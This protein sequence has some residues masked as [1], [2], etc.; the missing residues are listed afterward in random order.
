[1]EKVF[2]GGD[3]EYGVILKDNPT[4]IIPP[5]IFE[6]CF[7]MARIGTENEEMPDKHPIYAA[8]KDGITIM[9]DGAAFEATIPP[10]S[11][12]EEFKYYHEKARDLL[13]D[14]V[15]PFGGEI[16]PYP[17]YHFHLNNMKN[18]GIEDPENDEGLWM[19][20]QFGCDAQFNIH[21]RFQH[22]AGKLKDV[23]KFTLRTFGGHIHFSME[24]IDL[25]RLVNE[26]IS[27]FDILVTPVVLGYS[28]FPEQEKERQQFYGVPGNHRLPIYGEN[29]KGLEYRTPSNSYL[30]SRALEEIW[31]RV[32][33]MIPFYIRRPRS[34]RSLIENNLEEA[35]EVILSASTDECTS[36]AD[37]F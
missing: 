27:L 6:T 19:A 25:H 36:F 26:V 7:G 15:K 35:I 10:A 22:T 13:A 9:A 23:K 5:F 14:L 28:P 30:F 12:F 20:T 17:S 4:E 24:T 33:D 29:V 21:S 18:Y 32:T 31:S 16:I 1:M 8:S 34:A 3:P 2:V 37:K 11:T